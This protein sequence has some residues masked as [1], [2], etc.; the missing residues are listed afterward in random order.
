MCNVV[1]GNNWISMNYY[2]CFHS[3]AFYLGSTCNVLSSPHPTYKCRHF[4]QHV[5]ITTIKMFMANVGLWTQLHW[6]TRNFS[7]CMSTMCKL[8]FPDIFLSLF[9]ENGVKKKKDSQM[10][11]C[12]KMELN[13]QKN[14]LN[15][16]TSSQVLCS[17]LL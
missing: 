13:C 5:L 14:H 8:H 12:E 2:Y 4:P 9:L 7:V 11:T 16:M 17:A 10:Q 1:L 6:K 15:L 3:T